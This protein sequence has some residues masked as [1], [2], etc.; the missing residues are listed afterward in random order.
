MK[1]KNIKKESAIV[2][3]LPFGD[4]TKN[5]RFHLIV[6]FS[7]SIVLYF[8]TLFNGYAQDDAI[9]ITE[10]MF[11]K[12]GL[13]GIYGLL[14]N[15]TFYGFFKKKGKAKLVS[16]GRY[17]P[18]SLITFSVENQF[19]GMNPTISH[20]IN[21]L[22]Y[23]L[24]AIVMYK[25]LLLVFSDIKYKKNAGLL[26]F[27]STMIFIGHPVHTEVVAN[28]KGRDELFVLLFSLSAFIYSVKWFKTKKIKYQIIAFF[29]FLLALF[30]KENAIT[31]L[32]VV[33]LIYYLFIS[34]K[35]SPFF[36]ILMPFVGATIIFMVARTLVLG[37]DF[38][39]EPMELMNNPFLKLEEGRFVAFTFIE[40]FATI[41]FSL[42]KYILLL[43]FPYSLTNDY[44]P[45]HISM[46]TF[47]DIYVLI[48]LVIYIS[49]LI[50]ALINLRKNKII[51]FAIMYYLI[52]L[53]IVSNIVFP[54][55]TNMSERFIFIPSLGFSI[56]ISYFLLNLFK[57]SKI[58]SLGLF[59]V[60]LLLYSVKTISRNTVWENDFT[61]FTT[62][63]KVS[64]NSAKALNAAGGSLVDAAFDEKNHSKKNRMLKE[65]REYLKKA[66]IIYPNYKNALL[67][68]GNA[69]YFLK[70]YDKAIDSYK[71]AL[72]MAP[73]YKEAFT[74]LAISY[75]DAGKYY[76][77]KKHNLKKAIFY[78]EKAYEMNQEDYETIR[79]YGVAMAMSGNNKKAI[80][81]FKKAVSI[82]PKNA[83]AYLNLG[84]AFFNFGDK[85]NG[86]KNHNIARKIDPKVFDK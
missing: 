42:G 29:L 2:K 69:N 56:I 63:V 7:F 65:A 86:Q 18:F 66:L 24:L 19:F 26:A 25:F 85:L 58:F 76:G 15:D 45:R 27:I 70:D 5:T 3:K 10:N 37:F 59:S 1:K 82:E 33:L 30:S 62:D 84:N 32:A 48:S 43:I 54:V 75:R 77:E 28:I 61:L 44:Y 8:N 34:G 20:L 23:G 17:R 22:L 39:S 35:K 73:N 68:L 81:L 52:T 21:L 11:T 83:G 4:W 71:K 53:S 57:K 72:E 36:K 49:M 9:V 80:E 67:I 60:I 55:G 6:V 51:S 41:M 47:S 79:L 74:N 38:G 50:Y 40:K 31:F 12:K 14:T 16:G 64:S 78:L 13:S 46:M